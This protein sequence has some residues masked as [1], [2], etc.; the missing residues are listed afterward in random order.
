MKHDF[1]NEPWRSWAKLEIETHKTCWSR[2]NKHR[3]KPQEECVLVGA[4][5]AQ[6][7]CMPLRDCI[8]QD[9][10][11]SGTSTASLSHPRRESGHFSDWKC[12]R[13]Q[14]AST[15]S[16]KSSKPGISS[17][18]NHDKPICAV[19]SSYQG[20]SY[21]FWSS[22][23]FPWGIQF[24]EI[25]IPMRINWYPS[26]DELDE[27]NPTNLTVAHM[28]HFFS[29]ITRIMNVLIIIPLHRPP[30]LNHNILC[31][32]SS[33]CHKFISYPLRCHRCRGFQN[34]PWMVRW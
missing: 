33:Y 11:C 14:N 6:H 13:P 29:G 22:I 16:T 5:N 23:P 28:A 24:H 30:S 2:Q 26:L 8:Q 32:H 9:W 25:K 17:W 31:Y 18:I 3:E 19:I 12:L 10:Q 7:W 4:T 1:T 15:K 20:D 21:D 27:S 34:P